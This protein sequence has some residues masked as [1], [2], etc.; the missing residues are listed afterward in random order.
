MLSNDGLGDYA[1]LQQSLV[2]PEG[3]L[4][5]TTATVRFRYIPLY[6]V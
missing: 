4:P 3:D 2:A 1:H 5:P 6:L